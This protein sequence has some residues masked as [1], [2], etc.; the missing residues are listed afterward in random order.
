M[1][2][3]KLLNAPLF[4]QSVFL[5]RL[6]T[7]LTVPFWL[8]SG[9]GLVAMAVWLG[10][11]GAPLGKTIWQAALGAVVIDIGTLLWIR[12]TRWATRAWTLILYLIPLAF[13]ITYLGCVVVRIIWLGEPII[14]ALMG[15]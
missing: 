5:K 7:L 2:L 8:I 10:L 11:D 4:E 13:V 14:S 1:G 9:I 3:L 15:K 6:K 12:K